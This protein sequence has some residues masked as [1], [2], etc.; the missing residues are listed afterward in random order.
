M[1]TVR[2]PGSVLQ[3]ALTHSRTSGPDGAERRGYLQV[4]PGVVV[5][6]E[7]P[8]GLRVAS[9]DDADGD[10]MHDTQEKKEATKKAAAAAAAAA[11]KA[12]V[13]NE[14]AD[15]E[16]SS[17]ST[18]ILFDDDHTDEAGTG[19][20]SSL[21][22][23][24][25]SSSSSSSSSTSSAT[26]SSSPLPSAAL[27][28]APRVRHAIVSIGGEPFDASREY[29][30][31]LPRNLLKGFCSITPLVEWFKTAEESERRAVEEAAAA[32]EAAASLAKGGCAE[33]AA[34]AAEIASEVSLARRLPLN[35]DAFIPCLNLAVSF[36]TKEQWRRLAFSFD[37]IDTDGNGKIDRFEVAAA[38]ERRNRGGSGGGGA[39][40]FQQLQSDH[41]ERRDSTSTSTSYHHHH[42]H[43]PHHGADSKSRIYGADDSSDAG[44]SGGGGGGGGAPAS[45]L[46]DAMIKVLDTDGDGDVSREEYEALVQPMRRHSW[47]SRLRR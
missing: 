14:G 3:A 11:A 10:D 1:V 21:S 26:L 47:T 23:S 30:V 35:E 36:F 40:Q 31:A 2:L 15:L 22:L 13:A 46:L 33:A 12:A 27:L 6:D 20:R 24:T 18:Y 25:S 4:D 45:V 34:A 29:V 32:L 8:F 41:T 44:V 38:F 9:S 19:A 37:E 42:H 39:F 16:A 43:H 7:D 28:P 17:S 5:V